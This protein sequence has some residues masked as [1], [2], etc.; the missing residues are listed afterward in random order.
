MSNLDFALVL[1]GPAG[2]FLVGIFVFL[3]VRHE[4]RQFFKNHPELPNPFDKPHR[5]PAE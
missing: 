4:Q 3:V 5:H 2:A 1:M